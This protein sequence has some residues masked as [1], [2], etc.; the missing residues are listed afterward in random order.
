M[1][2]RVRKLKVRDDMLVDAINGYYNAYYRDL[3]EPYT[4]WRRFRGEEVATMRELERQA[5]TRQVLGI[6]AIVGAIAISAAGDSDVLRR[7]GSLR[8]VMVLGGA[9][10]V[11]SGYQKG[12]ETEINKE[13]IE[14]LDTS[15][16][17]E[18]EP[19]VVDVNG[20]AVRLTGSA[21]QQYTRWRQLLRTMYARETGMVEENRDEFS[22]YKKSSSDPLIPN[23]QH[24]DLSEKSQ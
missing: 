23:N 10:A 20:E 13:A 14:E 12:K 1:L 9:A 19:L 6:A 18:A 4:D 7:T 22:E 5:L 17:A 11:Y 24:D 16:K 21:E 8:D 2:A 3:W 15:F